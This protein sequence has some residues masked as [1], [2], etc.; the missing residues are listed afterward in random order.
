MYGGLDKNAGALVVSISGRM[1]EAGNIELKVEDNGAGMSQETL[2]QV[3][4]GMAS[5]AGGSGSIGLA[6]IDERI[7]LIFGEEYGVEITSETG[8][9]TSIRLLLPAMREEGGENGQDTVR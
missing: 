2:A 9:G 8:R 5:G 1:D 3:R 7:R 4:E 6:N